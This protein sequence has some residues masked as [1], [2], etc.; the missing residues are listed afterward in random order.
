MWMNSNPDRTHEAIHLYL[1]LLERCLL[2]NPPEISSASNQPI[3][4][5]TPGDAN[6][7][8]PLRNLRD[9]A[10]QVL[11]RAV[12]GDFV[13]AG[14]GNGNEC[15]V[16]RA[17][18]KA[19]GAAERRL[20]VIPFSGSASA[21]AQAQMTDFNKSTTSE[22]DPGLSLSQLKSRLSQFGFLDEQV[23]FLESREDGTLPPTSFSPLALLRI[24]AGSS[25]ATTECLHA[26]YDR[27]SPGGVILI[28]DD[29]LM[30]QLRQAIE[31][32]HLEFGRGSPLLPIGNQAV[33]WIKPQDA[34]TASVA[35]PLCPLVPHGSPRPFWSVIV[36]IHERRD[37]LEQCLNSVLD[38]DPG[39][40][41]MEILVVDDASPTDM[42]GF[43]DSLG[44]G[45]AQYSR[46]TTNRGQHA[47]T[48]HAI[49]RTRGRWIHILHDDDWVLPGFYA[50]LREGIENAPQ[51]VGLAFCMYSN[52][53]QKDGSLWT[54]P[55]FR[56]GAG[57]MDRTFVGKLAQINLLNYPAVVYRRET[58]ETIGLFREDLPCAGDWE[59]FVRSGLKFDWH[60][61]PENLARYRVHGDNLTKHHKRIGQRARDCCRPT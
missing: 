52:F 58:F 35:P 4:A 57:L 1:T 38:Q 45:R 42:R 31:L 16:L 28:D 7:P 20:I 8:L 13:T 51:S 61:Q 55:P 3:G 48:N 36:P 59:F 26:L 30:P 24:G 5:A 32:F 11:T 46:N 34:G 33:Y 47:S 12:P 49:G 23:S 53:N 40:S 9:L 27:L 15:V 18:L 50:T 10:E 21:K 2:N 6:G 37:F 60:H 17:V 39:A 56:A 19:Y 43:V 54:P 44:R 25:C 29:G 41:D 14:S 22:I